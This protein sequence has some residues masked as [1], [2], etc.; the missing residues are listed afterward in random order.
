VV[1][2][3]WD[4]PLNQLAFTSS[5]A[6]EENE[7]ALGT[8]GNLVFTFFPHPLTGRVQIRVTPFEEIQDKISNP[9]DRAD[10][11]FLYRQ[12]SVVVREAGYAGTIRRRRETRR[13]LH[14]ALGYWPA[15]R[16][17]DIDGIPVIWDQP[18]LHVA[19]NKPTRHAKWGVPDV[20]AALPW[21][22]AY[23]GFLTDWARLVKALS[24]FA[25]RLTGDRASKTRRAVANIQTAQ[26]ATAAAP[27]SPGRSDAGGLAAMGP[28]QH[29]EAIP[30][31]GATIDSESGKP[32]AAM[33]AAGLG[34]SVVSLLADPGTTGARAV[35]ETLDK[36]TILEMGMRRSLWTSVM[37]T[38]LDY[39]IVQSIK[40]PRGPLK[41]TVIR[42]QTTGRE[43]ITLSGDVDIDWPD[44]NELDPVQLVQA[45]VAADSTEALPKE[46]IARLLLQALRVK[47]VD[48][49][50][51]DM[52][53]PETGKFRTP[54][55]DA[56]DAAAQKFR[57][58][59]DPADDLS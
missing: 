44:L 57:R 3:F 12:Y 19:V 50:L 29:L 16:P 37:A 53:D 40:A 7:R 2:E 14:P 49:V 11:W 18:M 26:A 31:T 27:T 33:V 32:L 59:D 6:Q 21:A 39:V 30:K 5:Q 17:K 43:T 41:G 42:D 54:E 10:V 45:I 56:G 58:G 20:Y 24:K 22:R 52:I 9:E 23:E 38:V 4:D 36:P 34:V 35:A 55:Q 48:E 13:V 51:A 15:V 1:Q 8:D 25:W 28:G 46:Q 47:D